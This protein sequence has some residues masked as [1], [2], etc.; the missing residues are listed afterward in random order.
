MFS[1]KIKKNSLPLP[2]HYLPPHHPLRPRHYGRSRRGL[3]HAPPFPLLRRRRRY[4]IPRNS[5]VHLHTRVLDLVAFC[6]FSLTP[7]W[8]A[9]RPSTPTA[10]TSTKR[11]PPPPLKQRCPLQ[12]LPSPLPQVLPPPPPRNPDFGAGLSPPVRVVGIL[13]AGM[14]NVVSLIWLYVSNFV[15]WSNKNQ[16]P[17]LP[18]W[19]LLLWAWIWLLNFG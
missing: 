6:D 2:P 15:T 8:S 11:R 1:S 18:M 17:S 9:P 10:T 3:H 19:M 7:Q 16:K 5:C 4:L 13:L 14:G 12:V